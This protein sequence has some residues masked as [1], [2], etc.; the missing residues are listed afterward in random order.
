MHMH[1]EVRDTHTA[2]FFVIKKRKH[3][4]GEGHRFEK[5]NNKA[6]HTGKANP[7]RK[8]GINA[9]ARFWFSRSVVSFSLP[10]CHYLKARG[11]FFL[12]RRSA[13]PRRRADVLS[14]WLI[15]C[16]TSIPSTA[17]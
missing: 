10:F 8:N 1:G 11:A 5:K 15:V 16:L 12:E 7:K 13:E 4:I 6:T 14:C 9:F 17:R 3:Y 2:L